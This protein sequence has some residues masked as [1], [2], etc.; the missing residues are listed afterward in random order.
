MN[1]KACIW[2]AVICGM[3]VTGG[4]YGR[5]Q[6]ADLDTLKAQMQTMQKSMAEMQKKIAELEK[7]KAAGI[8]SSN[9]LEQAS[10]SIQE[11]EKIA[12]GRDI[13]GTSPVSSREAFND[14]QF[15]SQRP[16]VFY[17]R[18]ARVDG[19]VWSFII[20]RVRPSVGIFEATVGVASGNI[21]ILAV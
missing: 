11:M 4:T 15:A 5:A 1:R 12:A 19:R 3:L 6:P 7:E 14:Q 17:K 2:L 9:A 20:H 10:H 18:P 21:V 16:C 13:G 8:Q